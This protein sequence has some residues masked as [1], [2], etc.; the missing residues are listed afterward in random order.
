[1]HPED[2]SISNINAIWSYLYV[3]TCI[4][5][6]K[7]YL[8]GHLKQKKLIAFLRKIQKVRSPS[9]IA[10]VNNRL[11]SM[12]QYKYNQYH[13]NDKSSIYCASERNHHCPLLVLY[14]RSLSTYSEHS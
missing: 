5:E 10:L 13:Y 1:M 3:V 7:S 11:Y 9:I 6:Y 2:N 4:A 8:S 14:P 12:N